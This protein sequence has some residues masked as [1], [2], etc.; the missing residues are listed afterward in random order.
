M[1]SKT[2]YRM[3]VGAAATLAVA[4]VIVV[5]NSIGAN[6]EGA[7]GGLGGAVGGALGGLGGAVSGAVGGALGGD[8]ADSPDGSGVDSGSGNSVARGGNWAGA[9]DT[10]SVVG[11]TVWPKIIPP[12]EGQEDCGNTLLNFL[13]G[14]KCAD[15]EILDQASY[16]SPDEPP[17]AK[18]ESRVGTQQPQPPAAEKVP[19]LK[20]TAGLNVEKPTAEKPE[21]PV[22]ANQTQPKKP[23]K[24]ELPPLLSCEKAGTIVGSYGFSGIK[25]ANCDGQVFAFDARRDGKSFKVTLNAVSGELIQVSK[26]P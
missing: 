25:P 17:V 11:G 12:V 4:A 23:E 10:R 20:S 7:R 24:V 2:S 16:T 9:P 1:F 26:V 3:W 21:P 22:V 14:E 8:A 6:G 18:P 15:G 19:T 5:Y 13:R